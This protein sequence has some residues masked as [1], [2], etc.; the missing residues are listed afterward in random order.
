MEIEQEPKPFMVMTRDEME[1]EWNQEDDNQTVQTNN[2]HTATAK[3]GTGIMKET[4]ME[5]IQKTGSEALDLS[6][7]SKES[8]ALEAKSVEVLD[9]KVEEQQNKEGKRVGDKI[10]ITC[11]HPDKDKPI[12][13]SSVKYKKNNTIKVS[14]IWFNK[15]KDGMIQKGSALAIMMLNLNVKTLSELKGKTI[16]TAIDEKGYLCIKAY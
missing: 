11:K 16:N 5:E 9:V 3:N 7:G 8:V 12:N 4:K 13:I 6:I 10:I 2:I 15:D 14:G 1:S